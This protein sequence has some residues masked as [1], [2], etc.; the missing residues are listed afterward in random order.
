MRCAVVVVVLVAWAHAAL[1]VCP[2]DCDGNGAVTIAEVVTAVNAALG[3][4][5]VESCRAADVDGDGAVAIGEVIAAV[6]AGLGDC[7]PVSPPCP[8]VTVASDDGVSV[9]AGPGLLV[10]PAGAFVI[11]TGSTVVTAGS[12]PRATGEVW[13]HRYSAAGALL[14]EERLA[15]REQVIF[16]PA[17]AGLPNAGGVAAW[18][19]A[20]P[21]AFESPI[22]RL[23]I[24]RFGSNG[25]PLGGVA[26]AANAPVGHRFNPPSLAADGAGNALLAW[27]DLE[28]TAIGGTAFSGALR[29]QR[30]TGLVPARPLNCLGTPVA[31][32]TGAD[33][34]AV[35]VTVDVEPAQIALRTF[36]LDDGAPVPLFDFDFSA[37]SFTGVN[38]TATS[39]RIVAV[40][41]QPLEAST[42]RTRLLA[43]VV[44][45]DGVSIAGPLEIGTPIQTRVAPV[46]AVQTD[47][48]FAVAFGE[49]P[50]QLRRFAADG[51]AIGEPL[52]IAD[53]YVEALA[54]AGDDTG[55]LVV[56][57]RWQDVR[58]RRV[59]APGKACQ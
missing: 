50:L 54:L 4:V 38:A 59:P 48:S 36:A 26:L 21:R 16:A 33:L 42:S 47:G 1:A 39:D 19:E 31:V 14:T 30:P 56:A 55:N 15:S 51:S 11:A 25:S 17:L 35:C 40:W 46:V 22:T 45:L 43:Q 41:R 29:Q 2:G 10:Q 3:G 24:R 57:W 18:G 58:A 6:Q 7:Q 49:N 13:L 8:V 12:Q 53:T 32:S 20:N 28:Q 27:L 37:A 5:D 34:G 9:L 23:A 44:G 52:V